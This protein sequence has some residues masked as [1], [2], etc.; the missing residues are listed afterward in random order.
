MYCD[1]MR[2]WQKHVEAREEVRMALEHRLHALRHAIG[3]DGLLLELLHN[4][5]EAVV[6]ER[7]VGEDDAYPLQKCRGVV[8]SHS[9]SG[10]FC[11]CGCCRFGGSCCACGCC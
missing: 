10:C 11:I 9:R 5:E 2:R 4:M 7:A 6:D 3:G 1:A 8:V